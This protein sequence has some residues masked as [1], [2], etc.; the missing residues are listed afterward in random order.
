MGTMS[1]SSSGPQ[2]SL[3]NFL[4]AYAGLAMRMA[5]IDH[6][7]LIEHKINSGGLPDLI[8]GCYLQ[9]LYGFMGQWLPFWKS[10]I[11]ASRYDTAIIVTAIINKIVLPPSN[12]IE[13]M[14]QISEELLERCQTLPALLPKVWIYLNLSRRFME[15][16]HQLHTSEPD[17]DKALLQSLSVIPSQLYQLF[18]VFNDK[19]KTF[20]TKQVPA[21]S[22]E[23]SQ[24]LV[25]G[26]SELLQHIARADEEL[27]RRI[28]SEHLLFTHDLVTEDAPSLVEL[29]W[30]FEVLKKCI[31]EGRME[32]RVQGV[33]TMQQV[34]VGVHADYVKNSPVPS[35]HPFTQYISDF[36]L[37]N[38]LVDYFVGV[39]SH[40][41][42]VSRCGNIIGFLVVTHRYT[43]AESDIIWRAVTTSQDSRFVNAV[44]TM[45]IGIFN[46]AQ[47]PVL[48]YLATKLNEISLHDFDPNMMRFSK[49]LF[50]MLRRRYKESAGVQSM[51]MPPFHLCVRLIRQSAIDDSLDSS[52]RRETHQFADLELRNLLDCGPSNSDR[53]LIYDECIKDISDRTDFATG[54]ISVINSLLLRNPENEIVSLC[55]ASDLTS[56]AVG[57]LAHMIEAQRSQAFSPIVEERLNVRF[58]LLQTIINHV[59][60]TITAD[61][62]LQLWNF[63]VGS[64]SLND[65]ARHAGWLCFI[66][67]IRSSYHCNVFIDRCIQDY[68]PRLQPSFY[69]SGCIAFVQDSVYYYSRVAPSRS[70]NDMKQDFTVG[71]IL[72]QLSLRAPSDTIEQK[73]ISMLVHFYL[74]SPDIQQRISAITETIHIDV[75]ERCIRQLTSAASMLRSFSDGTSS[76]EDEPMVIVASDD[77]VQTEKLSFSRSLMI[78]KEFMRGVRSRTKYS[79]QSQRMSQLPDESRELKGDPIRVQYQVFGSEHTNDIRTLEVQDCETLRDFGHRM[80]VLTGFSKSTLISGGGIIDLTKCAH[81]T[82]REWKL[83]QKGLLIVKRAPNSDSMQDLAL[84]SGLRP[85]EIEI[86]AHFSD[87]YKL[88]AMEDH[89]GKEVSETSLLGLYL[90]TSNGV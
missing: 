34:L 54:S 52:S 30:K 75:V 33:D 79:P 64:E 67:A 87:L 66:R 40:P 12:G 42:L 1:D 14:T 60:D 62:G 88:L 51:D 28:L 82:L 81:K 35:D 68:L 55:Q 71:E 47:Y 63:S 45:L 74:D 43:D 80:N 50:D 20:I 84:A 4:V 24:G 22:I 56:L 10:L 83:D 78:L 37:A 19:L 31:F 15:H 21:L 58:I 49:A 85:V 86:M 17:V 26:L 70:K 77:E 25:S 41:Q 16:Y 39:E 29:A 53:K 61:I 57:E 5:R 59:P 76:G 32:I 90:S 18:L 27:T 8:S 73:A 9:P 3:Q 72:W 6:Q 65:F 38:R 89:L 11:D 7:T 48:I 46:F 69:C 36:M 44:L 23:N 13:Y 2:S